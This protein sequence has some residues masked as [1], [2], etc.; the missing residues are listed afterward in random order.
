MEIRIFSALFLLD[1]TH[2][3]WLWQGYRPEVLSEDDLN[4]FKKCSTAFLKTAIE[5]HKEKYSDEQNKVYFTMAGR[6][7]LEFTNLFP[8]WTQ[9]YHITGQKPIKVD[10]KENSNV[11]L[12]YL[13]NE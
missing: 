11:C 4:N 2:E 12:Q 10:V 8:I 5:Y 13:I 9:K 6:E 1:N 3:I 7:P